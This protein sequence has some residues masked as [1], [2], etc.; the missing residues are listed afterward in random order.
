MTT[1]SSHNTCHY[2]ELP[3]RLVEAGGLWYCPNVLCRGPGASSL[4]T[5]LKSYRDHGNGYSVDPRELYTWGV[6]KAGELEQADPVLAE[7]I[8]KSSVYWLK[9]ANEEELQCSTP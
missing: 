9:L 7:Y 6:R 5:Q 1:L 8:L 4:R 2:C 3:H